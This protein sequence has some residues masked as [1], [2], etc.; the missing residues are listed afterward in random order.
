M[1]IYNKNYKINV[2]H[3]FVIK[4]LILQGKFILLECFFFL[5]HD[6]MLSL[7]IK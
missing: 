1:F 2:K 7:N 3:I 6:F 5:F 4:Y